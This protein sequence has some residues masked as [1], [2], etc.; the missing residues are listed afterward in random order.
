MNYYKTIEFCP[1]INFLKYDD[2]GDVRFLLKDIDF[3]RLPNISQELTRELV[4]IGKEMAIECVNV[5]LSEVGKNQIIY[6]TKKS[7]AEKQIA[8][9]QVINICNYINT[10]GVDDFSNNELRRYGYQIPCSCED[11][12]SV[13]RKIIASNENKRLFIAEEETE[14][15]TVAGEGE[16]TNYQKVA[17]LIEKHLNRDIDLHKISMQ[18]FILLK[19]D[20]IKA[21]E[22]WQQNKK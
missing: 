12:P 6:S 8:Y 10:F 21:I 16:K 20:T 17:L 1:A 15:K 4:E 3:E 11:I 9:H 14:L 2:A 7:I 19:I 18:K 13:L 22:K 5:E